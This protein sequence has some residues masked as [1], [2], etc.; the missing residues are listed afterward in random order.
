MIVMASNDNW[1]FRADCAERRYFALDTAKYADEAAHEAYR[2]NIDVMM[3]DDCLGLKIWYQGLINSFTDE[4]LAPADE[5]LTVPTATKAFIREQKMFSAS[6]VTQYWDRVI[7]REYTISPFSDHA[8]PDRMFD[9]SGLTPNNTLA[10]LLSHGD[11]G[12]KE[13]IDWQYKPAEG[14]EYITNYDH[15]G[16]S[17]WLWS[18][19]KDQVFEDF[20]K[21]CRGMQAKYVTA[22]S[23]WLETYKLIPH[24]RDK[25]FKITLT[26]KM[27]S[28]AQFGNIVTHKKITNFIVM[29][30]FESCKEAFVL[31]SGILR[32]E[33]EE[34]QIEIENFAAAEKTYLLLQSMY[35]QN[36]VEPVV[37]PVASLPE[38]VPGYF[39]PSVE[40]DGELF[41]FNEMELVD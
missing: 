25:T 41:S 12:R 29:G 39:S 32:P 7:S 38:Y 20:E 23:F 31:N 9:A 33:G 34:E 21:V 28:D 26:P 16:D 14:R 3:E 36:I 5:F 4:E 8:R 1:V 19:S 35:K 15:I 17:Q 10:T 2:R 24:L 18:V 6:A 40:S 22:S 13:G 37:E 27:M 11:G 30:S